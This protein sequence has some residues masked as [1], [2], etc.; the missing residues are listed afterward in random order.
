MDPRTRRDFEQ[1]ALP[2]LDALFGLA[3]RL[4]RNNAEAQDLVQDT[5]VRAYRFWHTFKPGTN[6][7]SWMFTIL[8]NTFINRYHES[9]RRREVAATMDGEGGQQAPAPELAV[10]ARIPETEAGAD[11]RMTRER[12]ISALETLPHDYR[13][14][15][16][17]ADLEGMSYREISEIME[18]P[19]GTVMS[20]IYRGRRLL[21]GLL[22]DHARELGYVPEAPAADNTVS[23]AEYRHREGA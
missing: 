14:A 2:H 22:E 1:T 11:R 21:H 12:I 7:R 6:A 18:C 23:L 20:R 5:V 10:T 17:L 19:I 15:V 9:R 3:L 4:T 16:M 8:R 13:M